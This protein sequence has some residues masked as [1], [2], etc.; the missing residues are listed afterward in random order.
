[1]MNR[2]LVLI[3]RSFDSLLD[4]AT[5]L[6]LLSEE[7]RYGGGCLCAT[8][9]GK[10]GK[11]DRERPSAFPEGATSEALVGLHTAGRTPFLSQPGRGPVGPLHSLASSR[12]A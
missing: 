8:D 2:F 6:S 10:T 9:R 4:T 12:N 1:M 7:G 11:E 5:N 3:F